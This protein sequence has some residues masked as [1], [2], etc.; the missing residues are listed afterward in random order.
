[1]EKDTF[2][3]AD[4]SKPSGESH[5]FKFEEGDNRFRILSSA[6]VGWEDWIE[7][8]IEGKSVRKPVRFREEPEAKEL[9]DFS[10]PAKHFWAFV[11]YDYTDES[12]KIMEITQASIRNAIYDLH[13]DANWGDPRGYDINVKRTGEKMETRYSV[14]PSPP[15]E[16]SKEIKDEYILS[17][18]NLE[19]LFDG[20]DPFSNTDV[21]NEKSEELEKVNF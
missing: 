16:V 20:A 4:Y 6:L 17:N 9:F 12:L 8:T 1:M 2:L 3:P 14:M 7:E 5:Y 15:K 18:I 11:V 10:K 21:E 19:A 13:A